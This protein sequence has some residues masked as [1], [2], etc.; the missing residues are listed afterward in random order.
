MI[1]D[2]YASASHYLSHIAPIWKALPPYV[3]GTFHIS[4]HLAQH[5][6]DIGIT[7]T[8]S[9]LPQR[10]STVMVASRI[11]YR[12]TFQRKVVFVEHGAGQTYDQVDNAGY[13]GG[14]GRDRTVLFICPNETVA[15]RNLSRYPHIPAAVV[16]CPRLDQFHP[17]IPRTQ[18]SPPVVAVTFHSNLSITPEASSA[19]RY[20]A[21]A[22]PPLQN[23]YRLIGHAHP[24]IYRRIAPF[25]DRHNIPHTPDPD[26]VLKE[27]DVV[28]VDNSSIGF[29]A[30]SLNIPLVWLSPP[31]YRRDVVQWPRF[32]DALILGE[33][34]ET[35]EEV[36][37]AISRALSPISS[38]VQA[39]RD[40]FISLV[41]SH[42]D[43]K[44]SVRAA[45]AIMEVVEA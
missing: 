33:H 31:W 18:S 5:A 43:G 32:W 11:D 13:S 27:A 45:E 38:I 34:A 39:S 16:G 28:V 20:C 37:A 24:Y 22:I 8:Q 14:S 42:R 10:G 1:L 30:A 21:D 41:Y 3:R 6:A 9:P 12:K 44:A 36:P 23:H 2:A 7:T 35:P 4:S 26:V 25:Y 40:R 29:E 15:Q 19:F 17:P